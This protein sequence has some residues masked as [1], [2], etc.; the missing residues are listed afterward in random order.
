M[1]TINFLLIIG[2]CF[3]VA[4]AH[5]LVILD[6]KQLEATYVEITPYFDL[7]LKGKWVDK[8]SMYFFLEYYRKSRNLVDQY[9]TNYG[10]RNK[11]DDLNILWNLQKELEYSCKYTNGVN[12]VL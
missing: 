3:L 5:S 8:K 12:H 7:A 2:V 1:K 11:S 4:C 9:N 6:Y 10:L